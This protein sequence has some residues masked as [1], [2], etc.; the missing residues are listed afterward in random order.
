MLT[1]TLI[2]HHPRWNV[3]KY[4]YSS[5]VH[6]YNFEVLVLYLSISRLTL[7]TGDDG[8]SVATRRLEL[9]F[10]VKV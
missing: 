4:I 10:Q 7:P 9:S 1:V 5:T 6:K 2:F 3:T 8:Q